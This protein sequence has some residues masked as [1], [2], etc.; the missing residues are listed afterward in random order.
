MSRAKREASVGAN[1]VKAREVVALS[2]CRERM[3]ICRSEV[4]IALQKRS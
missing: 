4:T 1:K 2:F 3:S